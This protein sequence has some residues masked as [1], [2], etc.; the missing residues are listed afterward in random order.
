[1]Q[2]KINY[3]NEEID[4]FIKW[5]LENN[6][7]SKLKI[8]LGK[9]GYETVSNLNIESDQVL[10]EI[11]RKIII[12]HLDCLKLPIWKS[13]DQVNQIDYLTA[14]IIW[15]KD[16]N[17]FK[18][19][20]SLL[21]KEYKEFPVNWSEEKLN[22]IKGTFIYQQIINYK[23][24]LLNLYQNLKDN[25]NFKLSFDKYVWARNFVTSRNF[26]LDINGE[27]HYSIV[28]FADL[29]NHSFDYNTTYFFDNTSNSFKIKSLRNIKIGQTV[30]DSYG[31]SKSAHNYLLYYGFYPDN[32]QFIEINNKKLDINKKYH[33]NDF[34]KIINLR[35]EQVNNLILNNKSKDL[36]ISK[37]LETE[38]NI[39]ISNL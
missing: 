16:N 30:T 25:I 23:K 24:R 32:N 20:F 15:L 6:G 10:V 31:N 39:L 5:F 19:Y 21:P 36:V 17:K 1:M 38:K 9:F 22:F 28:P 18:S 34:K 3:K 11:P 37:I 8:Q 12:T 26:T 2:Y 7:S 33:S 13:V 4:S 29:L 27:N 35:L 14:G